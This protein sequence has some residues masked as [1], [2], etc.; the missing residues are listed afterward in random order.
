MVQEKGIKTVASNRKAAFEYF[1]LERT[2]AGMALQGNEI[3]SIRAGQMSLGRINVQI[4]GQEAWLVDAHI[5]PYEQASI[6]NHE[7]RR[8]RKLLLHRVEI[9]RHGTRPGKKV[10][11][12]PGANL[13][14]MA[15]PKLRLPWQRVKNCTINAKPL[16]NAISNVISN[17]NFVIRD[18]Y[19]VR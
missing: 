4:D 14:N 10:Y 18:K 8:P 1:L 2:E 19:N 3:K 6:Y 15:A 16:Q 12:C 17:A 5:A 7:P 9:R 13:L 11:N